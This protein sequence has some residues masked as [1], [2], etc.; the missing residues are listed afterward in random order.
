MLFR[1]NDPNLAAV[2]RKHEV[3]YQTAIKWK[4]S[5]WWATFADEILQ[6]FQ[7]DL[8]AKQRKIIEKS[9]NE[10][11]DRL[12]NGDEFYYP[13]SGHVR[14]KVKANHLAT[15]ADSTLKANQLL[16]GRATQ[17]NHVTIDNLADKLRGI[18]EQA[19]ID[20]T[21]RPEQLEINALPEHDQNQ[22]ES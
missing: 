12:D 13:E 16:Q 18:T 1:S 19:I 20:I 9:Y 11:H 8:L 2:C 6:N 17:I 10:M 22:Q 7:D 5:Q 21:P 15:L 3:P 14:V 4:E